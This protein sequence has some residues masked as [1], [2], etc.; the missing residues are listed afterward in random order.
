MFE[1]FIF[2][3]LFDIY[4]KSFAFEPMVGSFL[5][6]VYLKLLKACLHNLST[7]FVE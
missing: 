2:N 5:F 4:V 1:N 7:V 3:T 6:K